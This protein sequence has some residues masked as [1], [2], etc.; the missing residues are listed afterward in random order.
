[1][2]GKKSLV[3]YNE[4]HTESD[5]SSEAVDE[6]CTD[7]D[8]DNADHERTRR[9]WMMTVLL[10]L[11]AITTKQCQRVAPQTLYLQTMMGPWPRNGM[12][13]ALSVS[14]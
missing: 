12:L 9:M 2:I 5:C 14:W 10:L 1:M 3:A 6:I 11:Q 13:R 7:T 4:S 8:D